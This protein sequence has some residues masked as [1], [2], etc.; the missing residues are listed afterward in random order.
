MKQ[1]PDL[2][3][4]ALTGMIVL[5][6]SVGV[7]R[8]DDSKPRH[9]KIKGYVTN[10]ISPTQFEIEDY[11]I[12]HDQTFAF[13][14]DNDAPE[15]RLKPEDIRVG[16]ELEIKGTLDDAGNLRATSIRVDLEQFKKAKHTAVIMYPPVGIAHDV[17]GWSGR[18][19]ADGQRIEVSPTT[20]VLFRLTSRE[21][22]L[23]KAAAHASE[24]NDATFEPLQSLNQV[25][26]GMLM[27]YEGTRELDGTIAADRVEFSHND[28]EKGEQ[29]LWAQLQPT[30]KPLS[31]TKPPELKI[32]GVG[33]FKVL[34]DEDVQTYVTQLVQRL[35]PPYQRQLADDDPT[36]LHFR[37]FVVDVKEANAFALANGV[38]VVNAGLFGVLDNEA[39]LAAVVGHEMA[40]ATQEHTWREMQFH[41]NTRLALGIAAAFAAAYGKYSVADLLTLTLAAIQSGYSRSLENQADRVGLEYMVSAGYDPR[42]APQVWKAMTKAY[43]NQPTNFFWSGH[44]NNA[45]RRSYLMN[46]LKNN[47]SQLDYS[48]LKSSSDEYLRIRDRVLT[49][50]TGKIKRLPTSATAPQR[51]SVTAPLPPAPAPAVG[52]VAAPVAAEAVAPAARSADAAT[53]SADEGPR[54]VIVVT[55]APLFLVPHT[56]RQPLTV[57]EQGTVLKVV[58]ETTGWYRVEFKDARWGQ[59]VG[60]VQQA[61]VRPIK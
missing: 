52:L 18:F 34:P 14:F 50:S 39:Q 56:D 40:H 26:A 38:I 22:K 44:D 31:G 5:A 1:L 21:K 42:Q 17:A 7:G 4:A 16:V 30:V 2:F 51:T 19:V 3:V 57:I 46:E 45:T 6:G 55:G 10:V 9:V 35:D 15:L 54:R 28:L 53:P 58:D 8:A 47:Y 20:K 13:E 59:R 12:T 43:G 60:Y 37:V 32:K 11:R 27:S 61:L 36:K 23:A 25:A 24:D 49:E 41:K 29:K 33:K 48:A